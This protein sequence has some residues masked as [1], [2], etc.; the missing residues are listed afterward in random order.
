MVELNTAAT[1]PQQ[2]AAELGNNNGKPARPEGRDSGKCRKAQGTPDTSASSTA[3]VVL[4]QMND[5]C[6]E[7]G[8]QQSAHMQK[9]LGMKENKIALQ[10]KMY[11][12]HKQDVERRATLKEEQLKLT[13]K[14]IEVRDKQ[15][16]AQLITAEIGIKGA[17]LEK[18]APNVKAYYLAMQAEILKRRGIM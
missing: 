5:R 10:E 15:T 4:Q 11:D 3:F 13:K 12:L 2:T 6:E 18:L 8:Q 7:S 1:K 9:M 16:E 14:D 17:D